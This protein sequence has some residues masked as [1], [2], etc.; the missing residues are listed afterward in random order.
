MELHEID[1]LKFMEHVTEKEISIN[2]Y[3]NN[4]LETHLIW[5]GIQKSKQGRLDERNKEWKNIK[6]NKKQPPA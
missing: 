2:E 1:A 6:E 5:H 3:N 4:K